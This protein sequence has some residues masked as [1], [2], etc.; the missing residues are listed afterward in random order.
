M[1]TQKLRNYVDYLCSPE[2]FS[3]RRAAMRRAQFRCEQERPGE[4]RHDGP[5]EV[6]HLHYESLG[7]ERLEDVEVLCRSCHRAKRNP[8]Y[9]KKALQEHCDGQQRLFDRWPTAADD[10]EAA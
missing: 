7:C 3:V 10:T 8:R 1:A 5:L 4:P 2:W 9:I 6:H